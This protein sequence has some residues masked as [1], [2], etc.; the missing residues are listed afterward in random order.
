[1]Y[2]TAAV[3]LIALVMSLIAS[4]CGAD[5]ETIQ[6]EF[7]ILITNTATAENIRENAEFLDTNIANVSKDVA[8]DM[9]EAYR[10][11]LL[12]YITQNKDKTTIQELS[13]YLSSETGLIDE[14]KIQNSELKSYY[15]NIKAGC[16]TIRVYEGAPVLRVDYTMLIEKYGEYISEPL[17]ELFQLSAELIDKPT[18]ENATL[19]ISWEELLAR[20]LEAEKLIKANPD[21][22][23]LVGH[24]M[25][26]YT[27]HLNTML[28]GTTNTPVFDYT[29]KEFSQ[30]A[31]T[32]YQNFLLAEPDTT[33]TW[34]LKEYFTYLSSIEF[35]LDFNDSTMSKVFFDTCD[36]LVAEAEKR[37]K[38]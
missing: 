7:A 15:D 37:V 4:G 19:A 14:E 23:R 5:K 22:E 9:V 20:T 36:W 28:M 18:S 24:A 17:K 6:S 25:W 12:D 16:L 8:T 34:V 29:T 33:M 21:N 10:E 38:E 1:M 27:S 13:V 2:K 26:I 11:Y 32:A 35:K 30:A 31:R 3:L